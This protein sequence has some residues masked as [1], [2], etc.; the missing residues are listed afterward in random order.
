V[1]RL[2]THRPTHDAIGTCDAG[3]GVRQE[4][5]VEIQASRLS[6]PGVG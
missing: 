2:L 3:T 1:A 4:W 6:C 5:Q